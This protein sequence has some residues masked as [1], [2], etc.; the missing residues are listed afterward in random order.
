MISFVHR[1]NPEMASYR[2][3]AEIPAKQLGV[4]LNGSWVTAKPGV[5]SE[6]D[7]LIF[8]KPLPGDIELAKNNK[9]INVVDIC[10]DHL[11]T[12]LYQEMLVMADIITCPTRN[13]QTRI[14][15][16]GKYA[17]IVP[18]PYEFE[19]KLPHCTGN[20]LIW[21]GH[22]LNLYSLNRILPDIKDF[23]L[24]VVSNAPKTIPWSIDRLKQELDR[25]D[26]AIFPATK[27]YKSPNRV[28]EAIRRGCFIVA[29]PQ[30]SLNEFEGIWLG[31]ISR[32]IE[33][34]ISDLK[35]ANSWTQHAQMFIQDKYS[36][37]TQANVWRRILE[38]D[39]T[40]DV[41]NIAGMVGSI[42]T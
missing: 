21:F 19:E 41:A 16:F 40:L 24:T 1:G 36:P 11:G 3:R 37:K 39:S 17:H 9:D 12:D 5:I 7:I 29:E 38:L 30:P 6:K 18:D 32:G 4:Q 25:A 15:S 42:L 35:R 31:D 13:M 14:A 27:D 2:Y 34:A 26:I 33:F 23:P 8:A 20:N 22:K 28:L 10:D